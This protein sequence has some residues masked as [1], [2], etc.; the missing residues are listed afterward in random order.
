MA[1]GAVNGI[2]ARQAAMRPRPRPPAAEPPP[3]RTPTSTTGLVVLGCIARPHGV[4]G[5]LRVKLY[6][7]ESTAITKGRKITLLPRAALGRDGRAPSAPPDRRLVESARPTPG[8]LLVRL[9]HCSDRDQALALQGAEIAVDR[10]ELPDLPDGEFYACDIE[11]ARVE[12]TS[13]DVI[14]TVLGLAS[15]PGCDVLRVALAE[16]RTIEVP[17]VDDYVALVDADAHLVKL[18][19]TNEL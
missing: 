16:G 10:D 1:L 12:L 6:N 3:R 5:E 18:H 17:L 7:D 14:G 2:V 4:R 15:Y 8:G 19:H 11:G 13:G 9:S